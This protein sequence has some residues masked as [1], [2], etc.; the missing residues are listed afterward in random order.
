MDLQNYFNY[1]RGNLI[2]CHQEIVTPY[3]TKSVVYADW[4]ASGRLYQPIEQKLSYEFGP[5]IANT[6]SGASTTGR[7]STEAYEY[8]RKIVKE[9]VNG[10]D[11][12]VILFCG[13]GMT[14][15]VNKLQRI[16]GLKMGTPFTTYEELD[17]PVVFV[18]HM[19]HHS[20]HT[21]WLATICQVVVLEPD[22]DGRVSVDSL[23]TELERYADR[24]V[25]IGA[26]T[27][28]SNVTGV[29]VDY[30]GLAKMMH[31]YGGICMVDFACSA[32]YASINMHPEDPE[33]YLDALC[34]SP[35][36]FLGGPGSSGVLIFRPQLCRGETP[37]IVGGGTVLWTNPWGQ[38]RYVNDIQS[39]EDGGTPGCL[40][41]I[42][43]ALSIR[44]KDQM[45]VSNME[46]RE[47]ELLSLFFSLIQG[48]PGFHILEENAKKRLPVISF[49]LEDVHFSLVVKL[50]NDR[51]GIQARGGCSCAGT[52]GHYLLGI[53][54]KQSHK[55]TRQINQG[56]YFVKPG[57]VR[58]SL[59]PIMTDEEIG[60]IA[61]GI[62]Q[63]A[64]SYIDWEKDYYY[65]E[66]AKEYVSRTSGAGM[67]KI[68]TYF[69]L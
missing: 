20:N 35:H 52:Y 61:D 13:F 50:L 41:A 2:G 51:F 59:H 56:N 65:D 40:Q 48:I 28:A 63:I 57:W 58:I 22:A 43:A 32:P 66:T 54:R 29:Q 62:R 49:Y 36:K 45:G 68:E 12:D 39:R 64:T 9:H 8:A 16:L 55:I 3:G 5:F 53:T 38:F 37:D 7:I 33:G 4:T 30:H 44:L 15:A 19:E 47:Q 69:N 42:K 46:N 23:K 27:A 6:H 21:S 34:F 18:T 10:N 60:L 17:R 24:T 11:E 26:F 25:K 1:F 67:P 14:A 31:R